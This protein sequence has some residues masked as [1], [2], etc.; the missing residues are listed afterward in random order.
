MSIGYVV[1]VASVVRSLS[2]RD[3]I[4]MF[5]N[6]LNASVDGDYVKI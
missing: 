3:S 5:G 2:K 1:L 4:Y 6:S